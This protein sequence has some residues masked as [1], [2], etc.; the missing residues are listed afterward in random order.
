MIGDDILTDISG[1]RTM[2]IKGILVRTGKYRKNAA[3]HSLVKPD[4]IIDSIAQLRDI[5]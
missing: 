5:L 2:G 1:A 4:C 3:D